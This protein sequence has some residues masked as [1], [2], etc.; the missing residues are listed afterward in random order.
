MTTGKCSDLGFIL[1]DHLR[2][3][4]RPATTVQELVKINMVESSEACC[5]Q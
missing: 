3:Q 5:M 1:S 2:P 4:S